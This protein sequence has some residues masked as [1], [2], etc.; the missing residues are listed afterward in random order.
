MYRYLFG[1]LSPGEAVLASLWT[2]LMLFGL[3][4]R[5][6]AMHHESKLER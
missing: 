4:K 3:V 5:V 1:G 2:A 6:I